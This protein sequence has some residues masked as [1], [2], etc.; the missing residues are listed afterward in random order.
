MPKLWGSRDVVGWRS[1]RRS[2]RLEPST[3]I[4]SLL[5]A[6]VATSWTVIHLASTWPAAPQVRL[7][8]TRSRLQLWY[9]QN[10]CDY[11]LHAHPDSRPTDPWRGRV[12]FSVLWIWVILWL[13]QWRPI[14]WKWCGMIS[15]AGSEKVTRLVSSLSHVG[16]LPLEPSH[17]PV[18]KPNQAREGRLHM[19][20]NWGLEPKASI[21]TTHESKRL[22]LIPAPSFWDVQS[23]VLCPN[24]WHKI[25]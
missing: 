18:R 2:L 20:K 10:G 25:Y 1:A 15:E 13:Q 3:Q 23:P 11:I 6:D 19:E 14:E 22:Q 5:A 17:H 21:S 12:Y 9:S 8:F 4:S 16:H 24:S 7:C